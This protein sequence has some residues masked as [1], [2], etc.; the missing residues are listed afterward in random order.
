M[1]PT[2]NID[3][4]ITSIPLSYATCSLGSPSTTPL[5]TKLTTLRSAS[6]TGIELAFPD[7][8]AYANTHNPGTT[9]ILPTDYPALIHAAASIRSLCE[10]HNLRTMMLQ[11]FANF[12]GWPRGSAE[13]E[14]AFSRA[15]GWSEIMEALGTDLL[16]IGST[17]TPEE[18]LCRKNGGVDREAVVEDLRELADLLGR[19]GQR[20]AYEN[21]CWSTHAPNWKDVWEIVR[22]VGRENVGLCLD[23]FQTAGGEWGDPTAPEGVVSG[24]EDD[25]RKRYEYSL[26]ELARTVPAEKIFLLQVSDAYKPLTP[27]EDEVVDGARPRARWSHDFRP[28]P[29]HGGYLPIEEVGRAVL[30]TGFRGWFSMEIF[31]G[32]KTGEEEIGDVEGFAR[33]AM[34]SMRR[35]LERCAEGL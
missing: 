19:K 15:K 22:D 23:T 34:G 8:L 4:D 20:I 26:E 11:P 14:D 18:K 35:F 21:W 33:E 12:E 31:D 32:G 27:F 2:P 6:F 16:Q 25:V 1:S 28:M 24:G 10:S 17:D 3:I 9:Q 13:R 29:Y 5:E 30:R 7:L